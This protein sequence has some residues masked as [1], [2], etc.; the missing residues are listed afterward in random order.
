MIFFFTYE[1]QTTR[2]ITRKNPTQFTRELEFHL[3]FGL[4]QCYLLFSEKEPYT[5]IKHSVD[6]WHQ[7]KNLSSKLTQVRAII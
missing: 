5:G 6:I 3:S 1:Y 7:A 4:K 2:G